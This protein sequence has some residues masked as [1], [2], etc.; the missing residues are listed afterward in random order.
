M[1]LD[2]S[3]LVTEAPS[4]PDNW[5]YVIVGD[6]RGWIPMSEAELAQRAADALASTPTLDQVKATYKKRVDDDAERIRN[7]YVTPGT[8]MALTYQE[9]KDQALAVIALG[10]QAANA[11]AND[12][13]SEFPTLAAS[14]GTE[15]ETLFAAAQLVIQRYETF[16]AL[17]YHIERTRLSAKKSISEASDAASVKTAYEAIQWQS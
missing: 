17:S 3:G 6:A 16:A 15:A 8:G 13:E 1:A 11:L 7:V 4:D 14:V 10:E 9:K 2:L 5:R 12:G